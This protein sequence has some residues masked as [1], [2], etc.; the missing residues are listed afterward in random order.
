MA[1]WA[2]RAMAVWQVEFHIVPRR[3]LGRA[4]AAASQSL[5]PPSLDA[6]AW[7]T[8]A[9]LPH[10]YRTRLAGV[11]LP[12]PASSADLETWG[13]AEGNRVDVW[14]DDG[15][16]RSVTAQIDVRK[17]DSRFGASLLVFVRAAQAVLVR[18]DGLVVEPT[19]NAYSAALRTSSAWRYASDPATWLAAQRDDD[20]P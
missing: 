7:W 8:G 16:V 12:T 5:T 1:Y 15:R 14:S 19:I 4:L 17:L 9:A 20:D 18:R 10:D 2:R 6:T 3:A 13:E 11:A